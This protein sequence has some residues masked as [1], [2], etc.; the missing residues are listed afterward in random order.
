M[1]AIEAAWHA[2]EDRLNNRVVRYANST[3]EPNAS[4]IS[5]LIGVN[6]LSK[7]NANMAGIRH[8]LDAMLGVMKSA[9]KTTQYRFIRD[10]SET[11]YELISLPYGSVIRTITAS[12]DNTDTTVGTVFVSC[13]D[14]NWQ[15]M[16][17][18]NIGSDALA[19]YAPFDVLTEIQLL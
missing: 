1:H 15:T 16:R 5:E 14:G 9:N 8:A 19:K 18:T 11:V 12:D 2:L 6:E 13:G 3:V 7:I 4:T 17:G 10:G